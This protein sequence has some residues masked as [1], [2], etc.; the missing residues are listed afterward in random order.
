MTGTHV[1]DEEGL[2]EL[3]ASIEWNP[4]LTRLA[5][6]MEAVDGLDIE[7]VAT[8][9]D[10]QLKGLP[11]VPDNVRPVHYVPLPQLLPTCSALIHHGGIGT[12][13]AA[14]ASK[15]PQL[16]FDTG[17]PARIG[18]TVLEDGTVEY[19]LPDKKVEATWTSNFVIDRGAGVRLNHKT[20]SVE[21]MRKQ[22][23]QVLYSPSFQDGAQALYDEWL[24]T[25]G[26]ND[27]V[28]V[29]ETLTAHHR[30]S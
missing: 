10:G 23:Q 9:S 17:E 28:P 24:A 3:D 1:R 11:P 30:A 29:L 20:Q 26:P 22:L 6:L 25:P 15:V 19:S 18:I 14:T 12:L 4:E 7:V 8:L 16:I 27:I 5:M 13:A 21:D 2:T